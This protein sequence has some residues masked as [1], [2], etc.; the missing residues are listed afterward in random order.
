MQGRRQPRIGRGG[1]PQSKLPGISPFIKVLFAWLRPYRY[2]GEQRLY[3]DNVYGPPHEGGHG[4][5]EGD[6]ARRQPRCTPR[7]F[8]SNELP[9]STRRGI[10]PF[11]QAVPVPPDRKSYQ[12][13]MKHRDN[14]YGPSY[15]GG[16][17][18]AEGDFASGNPAARCEECFRSKFLFSFPVLFI[19][20]WRTAIPVSM[21]SPGTSS[22]VSARLHGEAGGDFARQPAARCEEYFH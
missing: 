21:N 8:L 17:G 6:F 11:Y 9:R 15:E 13:I 20:L 7:G 12:R 5:A 3:R 1:Q 2:E 22:G 10:C 19:K 18:E 16:H 14:V 4:E